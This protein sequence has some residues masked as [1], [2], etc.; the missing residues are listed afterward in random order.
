[1]N[2]DL[3]SEQRRIVSAG[4]DERLL[5]TAGPGTG[6]TRVL[7]ARLAKLV[8]EDDVAPGMGLLVLSFSRAAVGEIRERLRHRDEEVRFVR[9]YTFDGFASRL[10]SSLAETDDR[11]QGSYDAR[12]VEATRLL[13][14]EAAADLIGD[15]RHVLV[16]EVQ[17]LVGGCA[18]FVLRILEGVQ[19]GFTLMGDPAQSIYNFQLEGEARREGSARLYCQVREC[20]AHPAAGPALREFTLSVNHRA[21]TEL[22]RQGLWAGTA[23]ASSQPDYTAILRRLEDTLDGLVDLGSVQDVGPL[24]ATLEGTTAVLC[25]D[26]REALLLSRK[27]R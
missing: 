20:F 21:Q 6:K 13:S 11:V 8:D 2:D 17:D 25:R 19:A 22:A 5:V 15:Y 23:L 7:V 1:M 16:D 12:I 18:D 24:L 14:S 4:P 9:V 10:L 3:T 27:L 26:N